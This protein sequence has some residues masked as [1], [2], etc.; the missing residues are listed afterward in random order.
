MVKNKSLPPKPHKE[1]QFMK[2]DPMSLDKLSHLLE[3]RTDWFLDGGHALDVFL[4]IRTRE[5]GDTDIGVFSTN[6]KQLLAYLK[7]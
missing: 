3:N 4:G 1:L 6:A 7:R 2:W 5:H